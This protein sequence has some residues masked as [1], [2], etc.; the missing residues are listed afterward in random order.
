MRP[1]W[2]APRWSAERRA[3]SA[4]TAVIPI[5]FKPF[6]AGLAAHAEAPTQTRTCL[7]VFHS[8]HHKTHPLFRGTGLSPGHRQGPPRQSV[9]LLPMSPVY[10]VTHVAGLDHPNL[11]PARGEKECASAARTG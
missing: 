11:L 2:R 1:P 9:D 7:L 6:V 10:S 4:E 3:V 8:R 5:A